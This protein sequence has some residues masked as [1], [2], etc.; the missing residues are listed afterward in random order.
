MIRGNLRSD[1]REGIVSMLY[2][3]RPLLSKSFFQYDLYSYSIVFS[4]VVGIAYAFYINR[5]YHL[6]KSVWDL[7]EFSVVGYFS[8]YFGSKVYLILQN[9]DS[10]YYLCVDPASAPPPFGPATEPDCLAAF[11]FLKSYG[12]AWYGTLL[13]SIVVCYIYLGRD[14]RNFLR[15]ADALC[16]IA[17]YALALGRIG[18][19]AGGCCQGIP[20]DS[21]FSIMVPYSTEPLFPSQLMMVAYNGLLAVLLF[22][23]IFGRKRQKFTGDVFLW[24]L[25]IY[26]ICRFIVEIFRSDP[27]RGFIWKVE[28]VVTV[29][30][31]EVS[32]LVGFTLPQLLSLVLMAV[33]G[34]GWYRVIRY[35]RL[36][37]E[38]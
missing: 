6:F 1:Y 36:L 29:S 7:L 10:L 20:T 12:F 16:P 32:Y 9:A 18:C 3:F 37:R 35:G 33:A 17:A 4:T 8:A 14:M 34:Y 11:R 22:A 25:T 19:F 27:T 30:G 2:D 38:E 5:R 21:W 31:S 13:G 24:Y 15:H 26:P 23:L 28:R